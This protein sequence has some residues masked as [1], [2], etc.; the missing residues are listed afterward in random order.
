MRYFKKEFSGKFFQDLIRGEG[1]IPKNSLREG[2]SGRL[3][4]VCTPSPIPIKN[5]IPRPF[6][7]GLLII[8]TLL[9]F[10]LF[11]AAG[12]VGT[13][14][15]PVE[16]SLPEYVPVRHLVFIGLDGWGGAYV[17]G[18]DMPTVE[19]MIARGASSMDMRCVMPSNSLPNWT[20]LFSSA[21]PEQQNSGR[22][23]SIFSLFKNDEQET[24][25]V[26]FY[27]WGELQKIFPAEIIERRPIRS[28]PESVKVVAD[29]IAEKKPAFTA[30]VMN[31]P[32]STGHDKRWG[33]AAYNAKLT[34][35]DGFIE[36]IEQAVKDA[37]I[38]DSTVF[39]LS[40]DHGGILWGH[41]FNSS[42][43]R[44]IPMV[45]YGSNI[46]EGFVIPSPLTICDI[47]PTMAAILGLEVPPEWTG[48]LLTGIFK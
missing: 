34:E 36:I 16:E 2:A 31:E 46:K 41:G 44:R 33:S 45:I 5:N 42:R 29:Y 27:E 24:R 4:R 20:A 19:R 8:M 47:A 12:C 11:L 15:L 18:A 39:M 22:I 9:C 17:S 35:L 40:A 48:Q 32:D 26:F 13:K 43:Q 25:A 28:N 3:I 7:A 38:Y 21:P 37:G 14:P 6:R 10:C 30:V 23:P 1:Y